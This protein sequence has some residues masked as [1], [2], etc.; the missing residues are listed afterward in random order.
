MVCIYLRHIS[1]TNDNKFLQGFHRLF[2]QKWICSF[3]DL[4]RTP[5][6]RRDRLWPPEYNYIFLYTYLYLSWQLQKWNVIIICVFP[7]LLQLSVKLVEF[8]IIFF[9]LF[10]K[11]KVFFVQSSNLIQCTYQVFLSLQHIYQKNC[12]I[13]NNG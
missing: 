10:S 5:S 3:F 4:C 8:L 7:Y 11:G 6:Q 1:I 13:M 2:A 9:T 12:I